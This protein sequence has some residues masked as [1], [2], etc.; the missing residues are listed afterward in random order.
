MDLTQYTV[1]VPG[2]GDVPLPLPD[3]IEAA[4]MAGDL[5]QGTL[6]LVD[7]VGVGISNRWTYSFATVP[8]P[9][10]AAF[11]AAAAALVARRRRHQ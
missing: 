2:V 10:T 8:E 6:V 4:A 1:N 5:T 3:A 11:L 7:Q 9:S